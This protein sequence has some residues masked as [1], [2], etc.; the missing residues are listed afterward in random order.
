MSQIIEQK[1]IQYWSDLNELMDKLGHPIL[2]DEN[3]TIINVDEAQAK[4]QDGVYD[5]RDVEFLEV[6]FNSKPAILV[7]SIERII[8]VI[9][10]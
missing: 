8:P 6:T 3:N 4:I 9:K 1:W 10:V 2:I 7:R 5:G